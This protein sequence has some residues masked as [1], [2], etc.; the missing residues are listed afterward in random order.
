MPRISAEKTIDAALLLLGAALPLSI[1]FVNASLGLLT[2]GLL[3]AWSV[4]RPGTAVRLRRAAASPLFAAMVFY[5]AMSLVA[6]L[7]G[8]DPRESLRIWNKDLH[9]VWVVLLLGALADERRRVLFARALAAGVSVAALI[10]IAQTAS[11]AAE[12]YAAPTSAA[13]Y[14]AVPHLRAHGFIHPVSYGEILGLAFLGLLLAGG[15][16]LPPRARR[17]AAVL[18]GLALLCNQTRTVLGS[19]VVGLAA[20]AVLAPRWRRATAAAGATG[21]GALALWELLPTGR[22]LIHFAERDFRGP[23]AARFTLWRVGW[24]VFRDHPLTGVGPGGFRSVFPHYYAG[25]LDG[26]RDWGSAHNLFLHQAAERGLVGLAGL[27]G[28]CAA[29]ALDLRA[30]LRRGIDPWVLWV[31]AAVA[32]F[33]VMNLTETAFQT[34]QVATLFLALLLLTP[35]MRPAPEN[36]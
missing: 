30:R 12:M 31:F 18:T 25:L 14:L 22:S 5:A 4:D 1:A 28:V 34:E 19:L 29:V 3:L 13:Y 27:A 6:G 15:E 24:E 23:Q 10:G 16:F 9:K 32:A 26:E 8:L 17:A 11:A 7:A 2:A 33:F 36:L 35:A 21:V 20:A